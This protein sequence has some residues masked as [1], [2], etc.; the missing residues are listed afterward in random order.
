MTFT[1][2]EI[3]QGQLATTLNDNSVDLNWMV[4]VTLLPNG[5]ILLTLGDPE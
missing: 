3:T 5:K 4:I 2:Q 1:Q